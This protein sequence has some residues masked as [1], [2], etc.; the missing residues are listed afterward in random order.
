MSANIIDT[1]AYADELEKAG[2]APGQA[3]AMA[4]ALHNA[5]A[6]GLATKVDIEELRL[7]IEKL[8]VEFEKL[9]A[10]MAALENRLTWRLLGGMAILLGIAVSLMKLV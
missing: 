8:R 9:R 3:K 6:G 10:E 4:R 1:L 5:L 2:V 7:E